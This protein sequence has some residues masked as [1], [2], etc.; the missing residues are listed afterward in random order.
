MATELPHPMGD[1][2]GFVAEIAKIEQEAGPLSAAVIET[3]WR[4]RLQAQRCAA[5][6][7][8]YTWSGQIIDLPGGSPHQV[9]VCAY[10]AVH[11]EGCFSPRLIGPLHTPENATKRLWS[12]AELKKHTPPA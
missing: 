5:G 7:H 6:D 4:L 3:R 11:D 10:A 8:S 2:A 12:G 9:M 1:D